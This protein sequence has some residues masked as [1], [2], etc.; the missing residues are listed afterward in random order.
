MKTALMSVLCFL[1]LSALGAVGRA[2]RMSVAEAP[3]EDGAV[4]SICVERGQIKVR[5]WEQKRLR[6]EA[7]G[8]GG[9]KIEQMGKDL[10]VLPEGGA[11]CHRW[12]DVQLI[13]P[14]GTELNLR[15]RSGD[16]DVDN[17]AE[18]RVRVLNGDVRA[19]RIAR[20]VEAET[21]SGNVE[22]TD[23]TGS[24]RVKT[25]SGDVEIRNARGRSFVDSL[26]VRLASGDLM[27]SNIDYAR[28]VAEAL[29]GSI[30]LDGTVKNGR[31]DLK[32]LS[33]DIR[34]ELPSTASFRFN[35][36][37]LLGGEF[38]SDFA[39]KREDGVTNPSL[40]LTGANGRGEA[41]LN[42]VSLSGK[43]VLHRR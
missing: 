29:S 35:V 38:Q 41:V 19:R 39:F 42:L 26:D 40:R 15:A 9:I 28:V 36:K 14:R 31:Y 16:V 21:L 17:I 1:V 25:M 27:L 11:R 12:R 18:A 23:I 10:M 4:V 33:G 5:G 6:V 2:Q 24:A 32:T 37:L 3:A 20:A 30:R 7:E 8:D 34:L 22:L 13:V 43:I